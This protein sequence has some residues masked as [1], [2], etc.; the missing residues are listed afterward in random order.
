M[1]SL[2]SGEEGGTLSLVSGEEWVNAIVQ[3]RQ[4]ERERSRLSRARRVTM[5]L[6]S[7]SSPVT[8]ASMLLLVSWQGQPDHLCLSPARITRT[9]LLVSSAESG[10]ASLVSG[11]EWVNALVQ[12]WQGEQ[13]FSSLSLARRS[14]TL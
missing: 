6:R 12:P 1:L 3:P 10:N 7:H 2:V 8:R 5:L 14:G 13:E 11:E 4:G 9:I